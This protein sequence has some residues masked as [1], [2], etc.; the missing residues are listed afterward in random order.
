[1]GLSRSNFDGFDNRDVWEEGIKSL[2]RRKRRRRLIR[3]FSVATFIGS[4]ILIIFVFLRPEFFSFF[5]LSKISRYISRSFPDQQHL[6][7][8]LG[9]KKPDLNR[10]NLESTSYREYNFSKE[11]VN[12]VTKELLKQHKSEEHQYVQIQELINENKDGKFLYE[13][14]LLSGKR[15]YSDS[16]KLENN[17]ISFVDNKGLLV[18]LDIGQIMDI[19]LKTK[20]ENKK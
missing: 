4:T 9:V 14:E 5:S 19:K 16:A 17:I 18:A 1:M 13:V 15:F 11:Q 7:S 12:K 3:N 8:P 6:V 2:E 20:T 10:T